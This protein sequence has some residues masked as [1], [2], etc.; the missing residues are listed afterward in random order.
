MCRSLMSSLEASLDTP[1]LLAVL[2]GPAMKSVLAKQIVPGVVHRCSANV[3]LDKDY[4]L[5]SSTAGL[6]RVFEAPAVIWKYGTAS[7]WSCCVLPRQMLTH[8]LSRPS[9]H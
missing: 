8:S 1:A 4:V 9:Q 7:V 3:S 2:L 6:A 5:P